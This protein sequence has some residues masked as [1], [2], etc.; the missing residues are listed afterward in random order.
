MTFLRETDGRLK[1]QLVIVG[2]G[3]CGS[4]ARGAQDGL[5]THSLRKLNALRHT[6]QFKFRD[7]LNK[8][9]FRNGP[10]GVKSP[11]STSPS[12]GA[13]RLSITSVVVAGLLL[14]SVVGTQA[15]TSCHQKKR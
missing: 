6:C 9:G 1:L 3:G 4:E 2:H 11:V 10:G 5:D 8:M 13:P 14:P 12:I 15:A 7:R